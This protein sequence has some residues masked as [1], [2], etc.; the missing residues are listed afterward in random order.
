M[1]VEWLCECEAAERTQVSVCPSS[2]GMLGRSRYLCKA[3][4]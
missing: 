2:C 1:F 3:L 4:G